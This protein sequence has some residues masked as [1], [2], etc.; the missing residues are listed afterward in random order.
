[1]QNTS[2]GLAQNADA[3]H[4]VENL[5]IGTGYGGAV[6]AYRL[7][8]AGHAVR[9]LEMGMRWNMPG[10]EGKVFPK[11]YQ[12][13]WRAMWYRNATRMPVAKFLGFSVDSSIKPGPGII[14]WRN[15]G[16]MGVYVGRGVGGG[17]LVNGGMAPRPRREMVARQLTTV[18]VDKFFDIYLPRAEERLCI[19]VIPKYFRETSPYYQFS[20]TGRRDAE[21]A[22]FKVVV[23]PNNYDWE[24][25]QLEALGEVPKSALD[26]QLMFGNDYG[27][28]DLT[29]TYIAYAEETGNVAIDTMTEALEIKPIDSGGYSVTTQVRSFEGE[30]IAKPTYHAQRVYLGAGSI[31]TTEIL[32]RSKESGALENL[33]DD[34][35]DDWGPNGNT[36][37]G[38]ANHLW[39]PTGSRQST[40]PIMGVDNWESKTP[41]FTEIVPFFVGMGLDLYLQLYLSIGDNPHRAK[42][43]MQDG[44]LAINWTREMSSASIFNTRTTFDRINK[45]QGTMYRIDLF[46]KGKQFSDDLTYHPLGGAVLGKVTD[47]YGRVRGYKDLYVTD[48]ALIPQI[49]GANPYLTITALAERL[50]DEVLE[51]DIGADS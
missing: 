46:G 30:I 49:L 45:Q 18:D 50:M 20:R 9:M 40:I 11:M 41:C 38:R 2:R 8:S 44:A 25:M 27:K 42:C 17:S 51:K 29:K 4:K 36:M 35:G 12:P 19:G 28:R 37:F 3:V 22:G 21:R 26:G 47:D 14:D 34:L 24:Y 6:A 48:A 5:V 32:L 33:S 13:D 39:R 23:V 7:A 31:G 15:F 10:K 43:S 16:E 1:M